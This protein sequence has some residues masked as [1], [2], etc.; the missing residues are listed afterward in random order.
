MYEGQ[1]MRCKDQSSHNNIDS[2]I[3]RSLLSPSLFSASPYPSSSQRHREIT[4]AVAF[5]LAKDMCPI[6]T[7]TNKGFKSLVNTLDKRYVIL[8]AMY[9][10]RRGEIEW[11]CQSKVLC[12]YGS[13]VKQ[14]NGAI[15]ELDSSLHRCRFCNAESML[16]NVFLFSLRRCTEF[17][18]IRGPILFWCT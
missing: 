9:D 8:P 3:H 15:H 12:N 5:Y 2:G 14:D 18:G 17:W 4:N 10:K 16:A 6:N 13:M 1:Q 11:S 7:V